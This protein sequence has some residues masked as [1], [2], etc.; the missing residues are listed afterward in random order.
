MDTLSSRATRNIE[1][2]LRPLE[3]NDISDVVALWYRAWHHTFPDLCHPDPLSTW[4]RR[5]RDE[6]ACR[7]TVWVA[8]GR[9]GIVGCAFIL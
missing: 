6:L 2:H 4:E 3:A 9:E 5:F 7:G 8:E 1:I